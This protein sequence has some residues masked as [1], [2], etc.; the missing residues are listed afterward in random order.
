VAMPIFILNLPSFAFSFID[1]LKKF[2]NEKFQKKN[3]KLKK[4]DNLNNHI[5]PSI[6]PKDYS[7]LRTQSEIICDFLAL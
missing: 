3:F 2:T 4:D 6:L 1:I 7:G 5:D